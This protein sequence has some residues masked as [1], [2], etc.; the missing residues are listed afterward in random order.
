MSFAAPWY[1]AQSAVL[2]ATL[3]V[4]FV[5]AVGVIIAAMTWR[6]TV[7]RKRL[8]VSIVSRSNLV[9]APKSLPGVLE[10]AYQG[11][12]I[13]DPCLTTVEVANVGRAA[14]PSSSFDQGRSAVFDIGK[15]II[16]VLSVERTPDSSPKAEIVSDG[17]RFALRPELISAGEVIKALILTVGAVS[18]VRLALSPFGDVAIELKDRETWQRKRAK[19]ATRLTASLTSLLVGGSLVIL[20]VLLGDQVRHNASLA[21]IANHAQ[22]SFCSSVTALTVYYNGSLLGLSSDLQIATRKGQQIVLLK[23][24]F[25]SVLETSLTFHVGMTLVAKQATT[26]NLNVPELGALRAEYERMSLDLVALRGAPNIRNYGTMNSQL[27]RVLIDAHRLG[28][29]CV[30]STVTAG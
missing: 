28:E 23:P 2:W 26:A 7:I 5:T 20:A 22:R 24:G 1:N 27:R 18:E 3:V 15:E 13:E 14:I 4:I 25:K 21:G 16:G 9:S 17:S 11:V 8:L 29:Q 19:R 6:S 10:I 12:P 30:A